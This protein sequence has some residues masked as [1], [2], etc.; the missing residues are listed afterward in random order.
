MSEVERRKRRRGEEEDKTVGGGEGGCSVER[1]FDSSCPQL[2]I[3]LSDKRNLPLARGQRVYCD[4]IIV[5]Q[6]VLHAGQNV[7]TQECLGACQL[8][9]EGWSGICT[10]RNACAKK[11]TAPGLLLWLWQI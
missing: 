6:I 1:P 9:R 8:F 5:R 4:V 2:H 7:L 10:G 11:R 3:P